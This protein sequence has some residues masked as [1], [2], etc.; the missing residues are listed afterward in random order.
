MKLNINRCNLDLFYDFRVNVRLTAA[1]GQ[2]QA[3]S[4]FLM[5]GP[6]C[7]LGCL[8]WTQLLFATL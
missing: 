7:F 3:E 5:E 2:Y 6:T 8:Q 4:L 1:W